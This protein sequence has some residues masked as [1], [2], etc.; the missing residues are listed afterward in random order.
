MLAR[1]S[2]LNDRAPRSRNAETELSWRSSITIVTADKVAVTHTFLVKPGRWT[3]E[4][5]WLDRDDSPLL[6]R[7]KTLVAWNSEDWFTIVTK[8]V[9]PN[10]EKADLTFQ[11]R[12]R[13]DDGNRQYTFVFQHNEL[14]RGEGEGWI[15]SESILQRYWLLNDP[16]KR[17]CFESL[18]C[19][20]ANQYFYSSTIVT[21]TFFTSVMEVK[22]ERQT[23]S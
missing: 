8:L 16:Q 13:I 10:G 5:T 1:S 3:L 17:T 9:F 14:G 11:H 19:L 20:N 2:F 7:G 23:G 6:V 18:H 22:M 15:V 21:G 12:G 4:G